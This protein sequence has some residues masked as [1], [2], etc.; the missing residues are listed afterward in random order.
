[1]FFV[2]DKQ[3]IK[4]NCEEYFDL[5]TVKDE[6]VQ[7]M[8]D[9]KITH[10]RDVAQN[11]LYLAEALHFNEYDETLAWVIGYLHDFARFGQAIDKEEVAKTDISPEIE[12]AFYNRKTVDYKKRKTLADFLLAHQAL[13]FGLKLKVAKQ[14]AIEDGFLQQLTEI[15]FANPKTEEKYFRM[16]KYLYEE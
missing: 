6:R 10:T 14:K 7:R 15:E 12:E 3:A 5:Y 2:F 1:M 4:R 8:C 11:S 16:K 9:R 13:F